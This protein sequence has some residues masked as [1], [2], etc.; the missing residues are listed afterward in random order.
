MAHGPANIQSPDVIK[1]FRSSF[2]KFTEESRRAVE[3]IQRDVSRVQQWL[4][5][6]QSAHW[7]RELRR[8]EEM[9]QRARSEYTRA[10]TEQGPLRKK[11]CVDEKKALDKAV[12]MRDEAEQKLKVVKKTLLTIEQQTAKAL[13]PVLALSSMLAAEAPKAVVRLDSML[14]KLDDYLRPAA[15][16]PSS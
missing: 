11:S 16:K 7:K 2:I 14:D 9:V 6:E 3:D 1:R 12:R 5:R 4:E 15:S 13:G 8:R 10:R